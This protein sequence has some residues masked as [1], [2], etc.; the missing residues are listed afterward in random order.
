[1]QQVPAHKT[2]LRSH[3]HCVLFEWFCQMKKRGKEKQEWCRSGKEQAAGR[4]ELSDALGI[5]KDL[6]P[7]HEFAAAM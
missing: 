1:M 5:D 7:P 3:K 6:G 2:Y 4:A